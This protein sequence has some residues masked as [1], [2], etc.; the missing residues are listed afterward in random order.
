MRSG[1]FGNPM[2]PALNARTLERPRAGTVSLAIETRRIQPWARAS[3]L[4]TAAVPSVEPLSTTIHAAGR[5]VCS[6]RHSPSRRRFSASFRAGV[7]T[8][9]VAIETFALLSVKF[10]PF[11]GCGAVRA[12]DETSTLGLDLSSCLEAKSET[13]RRRRTLVLGAPRRAH[14]RSAPGRPSPWMPCAADRRAAR[15][16]RERIR[17]TSFGR[18]VDGCRPGGDSGLLQIEG[19]DRKIEGH[20]LHRLVHRRHV[21]QRVERIRAEPEIGGREHLERPFRP[22]PAP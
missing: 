21:V 13:R 12:G 6:M 14:S 22:G 4:T 10:V 16:S 11:F 9:W 2:T 19:D 5:H 15:R 17:S 1:C 3:S 8:R 7:T 18:H 20:V